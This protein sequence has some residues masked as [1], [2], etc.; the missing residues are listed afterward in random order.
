MSVKNASYTAIEWKI[1]PDCWYSK[2]WS[3]CMNLLSMRLALFTVR[4]SDERAELTVVLNSSPASFFSSLF[5]STKHHLPTY[6]FIHINASETSANSISPLLLTL[7]IHSV[8]VLQFSVVL[9]VFHTITH[10]LTTLVVNVTQ[11][12]ALTEWKLTVK[13]AAFSELVKNMKCSFS[14]QFDCL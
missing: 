7:Q 14:L 3:F 13:T 5:S 8:H 10:P 1:A 12:S 9:S 6:W 4:H 2:F 11:W